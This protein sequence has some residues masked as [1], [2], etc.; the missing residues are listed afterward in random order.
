VP[1][2]TVRDFVAAYLRPHRPRL[3]LLAVLFCAG[4]GLQLA[5]PQLAKT[6]L[7]QASAGAPFDRLVRIAAVFLAVALLTQVATVAEVYVAEDLG[8]RTTNALRVDLTAHVLSLDDGFHADHGAGELLERIDGD[9]AAIAGFFARFVVHVLGSALFLLGVLALL[10]REDWRIG[11]LL[12]AFALASVAYLTCGGGFVGRRSRQS[13]VVNADLSAYLEERLSAL[14]DIKANGADDVTMRG[15]H[16]RLATRFRV[17]REALLAASLFSGA[18]NTA[19]VAATV[20]SLAMAAWLQQTGAITVGGVYLVFR[21]TGMLRMPLERLSRHMNSFQRAMGGIVRVRELLATEPRITDGAGA[22]LPAGALA[23]ELDAVDFAYER[24][25]VLRH[26]S[27]RVEPGHVLGLLGRT[28]SGKTTIARLLFRLYDVDAGAVR[29][30]GVDVRD[31]RVDDLR[32]RIGLV[33]QDVQ[34]FDGTLRDNV[35][36]FDPDVGDDRL[37][38]VFASLGLDEWLAELPDGLDTVL[39]PTARGLSAGEAQLVALA[40]VFLEDP[41]L[42]VLDEASSRLDPHTEALLEDAI[43]RLLADRT[44]IVIAH[45]LRTIERTDEV[46]LLDGGMVVEHGDRMALAAD[47]TSRFADLLRTGLPEVRA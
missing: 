16:E 15:L 47:P 40:R 43:D 26:L 22:D 42:V 29:V 5:N 11:G 30:G 36:L 24:E 3:A 2:K 25:P 37:V 23:V 27:C 31:L 45:R 17:D 20:A 44:G 9:V 4:I 34:L 19:L 14:P 32:R 35:R 7:D 13:R 46:L 38:A 33:T 1:D 21:Y 10:W 18:A 8:W 41:G 28:G 6:F 39:G 12:T